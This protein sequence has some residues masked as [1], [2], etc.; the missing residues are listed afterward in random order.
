M[1]CRWEMGKLAVFVTIRKKRNWVKQT[2]C[3]IGG[4]IVDGNMLI[5][6]ELNIPPEFFDSAGK[7]NN[8]ESVSE[9]IARAV[10][11]DILNDVDVRKGNPDK[12]EPD[13]VSEVEGYEVTFAVEKSLVPQLKG[14]KRLDNSKRE[15]NNILIK[16]INAAVNRKASK[17]YSFISNLIIITLTPL[18]EWYYPYY[19][20]PESLSHIIWEK[21]A[22]KRDLLFDDLYARYIQN[23]NFKNIYIIQPT[24]DGYLILF[25]VK[26]FGGFEEKDFM[27]KIEV[28]KPKAFPT[29]KTTS[30]IEGDF[31][32]LYETTI[33]NHIKVNED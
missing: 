22:R 1:D 14:L 25:D 33:I 7:Q 6:L 17:T 10:I 23:N 4:H 9:K 24:H 5:R 2:D 20:Q 19:I 12:F 26:A 15:M 27:A 31:P 18:L 13:Y 30:K 32:I 29:Y 3:L 21:R 8:Y 28:K 16:D 11:V